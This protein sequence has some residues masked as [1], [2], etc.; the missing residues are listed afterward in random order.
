MS[1]RSSP[2]RPRA[3]TVLAVATLVATACRT[4]P[5][6]QTPGPETRPQASVQPA[7][8]SAASS[9]AASAD[10]RFLQHMIAHHAQALEMT[11]LV[12]SRTETRAVRLVAERIAA[13][14]QSETATMEQMLRARSG[15]TSAAVP[16]GH[17]GHAM[18]TTGDASHASMPG[19]ATPAELAQ[20]AAARGAEFDRL[21][22]TLMIRHH[23]GALT[24][25]AE[26]LA[27]PGAAQQSEIFQLASDIDA[28]QRAELARLRTLSTP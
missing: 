4:A 26:L 17:A 27:T 7:A 9:A 21:F 11:A 12:P 13:S 5:A 15:T 2:I 20:L 14:Q 1:F 3:A 16:T 8:S 23:E 19:M 28:D 18:P 22:A 25:V 24:M 10:V 6:T